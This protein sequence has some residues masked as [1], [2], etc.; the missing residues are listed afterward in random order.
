MA[1]SLFDVVFLY[2]TTFFARGRLREWSLDSFAND[3]SDGLIL[4]DKYDDLIHVNDMIRNT[5]TEDLVEEFADRSR[6][7]AW[8]SDTGEVENNTEIVTYQG[9]DRE[10]YFKMNVRDISEHGKRI[11]TLFILH[12]TTDSITRIRAMQ[13]ANEE[14]ERANRM[15]SDFLANMSHE[16]R[17]PMNAVIG[18]TEI[19]MREEKSPE[20]MDYLTQISH[21]GNH[22]LNIINDI[23]DYSKIES[24]MMEIVEEDYVPF[25]ELSEVAGI[26]ANRTGDKNLRLCFL[27]DGP[28]PR[29]LRGDV[30]RI[31]QVL[32]NLANNAIKF[33][34]E[35]S[36]RVRLSF[37][38]AGEGMVNCAV[39]VIDTGIGIKPED[40]D[41]LFVS[42]Q[43]VDSKRNRSV[44]GTGLGL[45]ISKRLCEAM[46]GS[47]GVASEYGKGSDFCFSI[48]QKIANPAQDLIVQDADK[49]YA[50]CFNG[51]GMMM[52]MIIEQL[53]V[54]GVK[55]KEIYSLDEC[56]NAGKGD[57]IFFDEDKYNADMY[58]FLE[59]HKDCVGVILTDFD[60]GFRSKQKNL[61]VM[62]RP[63]STLSLVMILNNKNIT[64]IFTENKDA[65]E[66]DYTAP[67]AKVLI[68]DDNPINIT[69]AQGLLQPLK[70]QCYGASG[71]REALELI[72]KVDY[73]IILMDH[74]MPEMDGVETTQA[75]RNEIPS[76]VDVPIIALTANV[77]EGAKEMFIQAGMNDM[78]AKP[79]DIRELAAKLKQWLPDRK[80]IE[81]FVVTD[82]MEEDGAD[83]SC[84]DHEQA[85][86]ALGS[87]ALYKKIVEEYYKAGDTNYN[88]IRSDYEAADWKAY[89]IKVHALKSSSRQIGAYELG[90]MA[91]GLEKAGNQ[92]DV[93]Y[94]HDHTDKMME[95]YATLLSD[96][97]EYFKG[98]DV[99]KADLPVLDK[100]RYYDLFDELADACDNLDMDRME[101]VRDE[102]RK[103]SYVDTLQPKIE[104]LCTAIDNIDIDGCAQLMDEIRRI[105]LGQ[106]HQS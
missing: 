13:R 64:Q 29:R 32:I 20:V 86:K 19:A 101:A 103:H 98:D 67:D 58:T 55:G 61:R 97:S 35:G 7:E 42:F 62:R 88:N 82:V 53:A 30:Q 76:A 78:V 43:Q 6:L 36:V 65:F 10:Y 66:I 23:L 75:I 48:P 14:L 49:I 69:I 54:L 27:A 45:A 56:A 2:L 92:N 52:G 57:F 79:I 59:V 84:L 15:K 16:I 33:T 8:I 71:G 73:D 70:L 46:D 95:T 104:E 22:L 72:K 26:L 96:L 41:K 25:D 60:S 87:P 89:T 94:I 106:T 68:V 37:E 100:K 99:N 21:S 4:Y 40:L 39:H 80:I 93:T 28:M 63:G 81:G 31:R 1:Y 17:T 85:I 44:E 77:M 74:M 34:N 83:Y 90:D 102:F 38:P 5:L 50:Y 11:G 12:D 91:E 9:R 24:G 18:M 51:N 105:I 47:I 3:M